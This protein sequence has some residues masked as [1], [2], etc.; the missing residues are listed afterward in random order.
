MPSYQFVHKIYDLKNV[1]EMYTMDI[2][3][4]TS[5]LSIEY[6]AGKPAPAICAKIAGLKGLI[7]MESPVRSNWR[8]GGAQQAAPHD[9]RWRPRTNAPAPAAS[10]TTPTV[11][12]GRYVS[13]FKKEEQVDDKILQNI[14]LSKLNKFS[15]QTY[16]DIR[17]FLYQ[18]LGSNEPGLA[19]LVREFMLMVFR[20]GTRETMYCSLYAKLLCELS[21]KYPVIREEMTKLQSNYM[22]IFSNDT[23]DKQYR[24]GYSQFI[25]ELVIYECLEIHILKEIF[26]TILGQIL[27]LRESAENRETIDEFIDCM[28]RMSRVLEKKDNGFA[29]QAKSELREV[30]GDFLAMRETWP[31][32]STKSRFIC[33]NIRDIIMV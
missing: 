20:K 27:A 5:L 14:I 1:D 6:K 25:A 4:L 21:S 13:K 11:P 19:E 23:G 9:N 29:V 10:A 17:D 32:L 18:I 28:S 33:M 7:E 15:E 3:F 2:P 16:D 26:Q 12:V 22:S 31:G 30:L 24:Q 8:S